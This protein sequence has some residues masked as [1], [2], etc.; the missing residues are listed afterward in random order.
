MEGR[1]SERQKV[2]GVGGT[3]IRFTQKEKLRHA[4]KQI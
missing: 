4:D 1:H 3:V 2:C